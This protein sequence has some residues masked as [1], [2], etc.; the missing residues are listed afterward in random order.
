[1]FKT[2]IVILIIAMS[3]LKV[4]FLTPDIRPCFNFG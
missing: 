1:M 3:I 4:K 2:I